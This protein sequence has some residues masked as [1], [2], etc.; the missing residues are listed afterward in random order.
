MR[1]TRESWG[2]EDQFT[3][4]NIKLIGVKS[5]GKHTIAGQ[6]EWGDE[7]SGADKLPIYEAFKLGG[8]R[9][10]SG[11]YLDQ[12]TGSRYDLAT[13]SYYRQYATLP[14]QIGRGL[15]IGASL[16]AGRMNDQLMKD[17]GT[18]IRAAGIYF[19]A[20]TILGEAFIGY[21]HS[22]LQKGTFYIAIGPQF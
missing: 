13:L 1:A 22:S 7:L 11:L 21:G 8:P 2:S 14:S 15:Y 19:G 20:D 4:A 6:L 16:E 10:L 9:R 3:R 5:F 18:W 12:L 17:P